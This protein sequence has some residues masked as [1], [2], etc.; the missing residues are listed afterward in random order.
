MLIYFNVSRS[1]DVLVKKS[2]TI[3]VFNSIRFSFQNFHRRLHLD[4]RTYNYNARPET[5]LFYTVRCRSQLV[6][7]PQS[8]YVPTA[9]IRSRIFSIPIDSKIV[10]VKRLLRLQKDNITLQVYNM[11]TSRRVGEM[12]F[13]G[14][15]PDVK[16]DDGFGSII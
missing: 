1:T 8:R 14:N 7:L 2:Y 11:Y 15:A 5:H 16:T 12:V 6:G 9:G 3:F 13:K 10:T 4:R